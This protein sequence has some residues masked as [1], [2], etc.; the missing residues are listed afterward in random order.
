MGQ[1][2]ALSMGAVEWGLLIALSVVWGGAFFFVGVA[3][4][5]GVPPFTVV[6]VRIGIAAATLLLLAPLLR[7]RFPR[8]PEIWIAFLILG[9]LNNAIPF[10]LIVWGQTAIASGLA[11]ILNA[12][13]P[14]FTV[15]VA[16]LWTSDEKL[17]ASKLGGVGLG[18]AGVALLIGPDAIALGFGPSVWGQVAVLGAALSYAFAAVF[19]RRFARL[20]VAPP[21]AATGQLM[22]SSLILIPLALWIDRPWAAPAPS[23]RPRSPCS[24]SR[25]CRPP[26]PICSISKSSRGRG[27][28]ARRW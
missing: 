10:S 8:A 7:T 13:T 4:S 24:R 18:I 20:G 9:I 11:S 17:S 28:R 21:A 1:T 6:A 19:A 3:V 12:T 5:E 15:I 23:S 16:H 2:Q 27:P 25:R 22:G 14:L 26:S